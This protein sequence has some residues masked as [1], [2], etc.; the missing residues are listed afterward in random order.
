VNSVYQFNYEFI[1]ELAFEIWD[2]ES[3]IFNSLLKRRNWKFSSNES[4]N[5]EEDGEDTFR[6]RLNE[7][8]ALYGIHK[9]LLK[10]ISDEENT[11][12]SKKEIGFVKSAQSPELWRLIDNYNFALFGG[13]TE[14]HYERYCKV[15]EYL[16]W[17]FA[18]FK[19]CTTMGTVHITT[20][21]NRTKT[22]SFFRESDFYPNVMRI[23]ENTEGM[24]RGQ[25]KSILL[26][27]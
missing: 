6:M 22:G 19:K 8:L 13:T 10:T 20:N 21:I 1:S 27:K 26:H 16:S 2:K 5:K 25:I 14:A 9:K 24:N 23:W 11:F 7:D 4:L 12:I 3:I 18:N 15:Q 17:C